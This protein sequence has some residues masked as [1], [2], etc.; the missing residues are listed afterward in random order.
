MK[1]KIILCS[2]AVAVMSAGSMTSCSNDKDYGVELP[3]A[4]LIEDVELN[5]GAQLPLAVGMQK[6]VEAKVS[7][8]DAEYPELKW[9]STAP[10]VATV[11]ENGLIVAKTTGTA[12]IQISSPYEVRVIKS[13]DV[14]VKPVATDL[15]L[16]EASFYETSTKAMNVT[17]EPS[18]AYNVFEWSSSDTGVVTIDAYGNVTGVKEGT[19]TITAKTL[20]GSNLTAQAEVTIKKKVAVESI[21]LTA[22]GH[23]MMIGEKDK[24]G[25]QLVPADA[26]SDMLTWSSSNESVATVDVSGT[27]TAVA[28]G[29]ATITATDEESGKKSSV[30][31]TVASGGVVSQDFA[32]LDANSFKALGWSVNQSP[33]TVTF[34]GKGMFVEPSQTSG[35]RR[36]DLVFYSGKTFTPNTGTYRYFVVSMDKPGNGALKLDTSLG[37][38]GNNP[39]GSLS[40]GKHVAYYWD[41]QNKIAATYTDKISLQIKIADVTVEPYGYTVYWVHTFKTLEEAEAFAKNH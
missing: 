28:S 33:K 35:K 8:S 26:T 34:N 39:T 15:K 3:P 6:Q 40:G 21:E 23:D 2:M 36:A 7:N 27:V 29:T 4:V 1:Y 24:I 14:T 17:T 32:F 13:V 5:V 19:A 20:D 30:D 12:T 11:D 37:D 41:L 18:D 10:D 9:T 22:L 16:G 38:F 25:C 31:V